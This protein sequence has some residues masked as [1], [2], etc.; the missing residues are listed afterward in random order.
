VKRGEIWTVAGG[1]DYA[2]KPRPAVI[3]QDDSFDATESIT[4]CA[5]TTDQ[6]DAP[7][8][9]VVIEPSDQNGLSTI[10]RLMVDKLTTIPKSKMG[11]RIGH[12]DAAD[13][14]R[15]NQ[16]ILIF[17]GLAARRDR[18]MLDQDAERDEF[19]V[20]FDE[21][22]NELFGDDIVPQKLAKLFPRSL[23][24]LRCQD[25]NP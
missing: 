3:V 21:A 5:I 6:S 4:I 10:S 1:K 8:F 22:I 23:K 24:T 7:L 20:A 25:T 12:L 11:Y 18:S 2:G 14:I 17:L 15:V 13:L 16:A 9:R 19:E